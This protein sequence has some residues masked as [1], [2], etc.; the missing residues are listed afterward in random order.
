MTNWSF[1][2]YEENFTPDYNCRA[3]THIHKGHA[4]WLT[5][6]QDK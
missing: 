3:F 4:P 2:N 6:R 1:L 5:E